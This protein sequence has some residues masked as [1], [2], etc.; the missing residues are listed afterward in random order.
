[1]YTEIAEQDGLVT[2]H[3]LGSGP[4]IFVTGVRRPV[5]KDFRAEIARVEP[6]DSPSSL[7]LVPASGCEHVA[8][9]TK[10]HAS[11]PCQTAAEVRVFAVKFDRGIESAN[12][13]QCAAP[14]GK[15]AAIEKRSHTEHILRQKRR[16]RCDGDVVQLYER[17][18]DGVQIIESVGSGDG[19]RRIK[20]AEL[21]RQSFEPVARRPAI[22][23]K[24]DEDVAG[25]GGPSRLASDDQT[26]PRLVNQPY[27]DSLRRR[28]GAVGTGIVD[29]DD[30]VSAARLM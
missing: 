12:G 14:D 2:R 17:P 22:G 23:V 10:R 9:R 13:I 7:D 4:N 19:N 21:L 1:M 5:K 18:T 20:A 29:D 24:V 15:V 25:G 8:A 3:P 27:S 28:F 30:L 16:G 11:D 6:E 26:F